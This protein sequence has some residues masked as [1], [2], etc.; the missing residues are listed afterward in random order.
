MTTAVEHLGDYYLVHAGAVAW[1]DEGVI[2]PAA[3]GS[4]KSS[5]VAKLVGTG[6]RYLSDEVAVIAPGSRQLLPFAKSLH[7]HAGA[8]AVLKF[9]H[10]TLTSTVSYRALDAAEVWYLPPFPNWLPRAPVPLRCAIIPSFVPGARTELVPTSPSIVLGCLLQQSFNLCRHG[11]R[12]I[13]DLVQ[14]LSDVRCYAL[15]FGD[16]DAA[17]SI[18][19]AVVPTP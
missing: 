10:P 7:L 19:R 18:L 6:W 13:V 2:L 11:A 3:S 5:L 4:G 16:L 14:V 9:T 8:R 1:E 12:A 17:A 15:T